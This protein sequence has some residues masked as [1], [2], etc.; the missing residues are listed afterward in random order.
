MSHVPTVLKSDRSV[1]DKMLPVD[2]NDSKRANWSESV[3]L[4][5]ARSKLV[6][7]FNIHKVEVNLPFTQIK[8]T[9]VHKK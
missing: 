7:E 2:D 1:F 9:V 6:R 5:I 8:I 3:G 4:P